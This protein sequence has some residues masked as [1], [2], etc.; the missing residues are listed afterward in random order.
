[1]PKKLGA[2]WGQSVRLA[3]AFVL[4]P[5]LSVSEIAP[6]LRITIVS[7]EFVSLRAGTI[8][9]MAFVL[10]GTKTQPPHRRLNDVL[11]ILSR[12]TAAT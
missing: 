7:P 4:A 6:E 5:T 11:P 1:M 2:P 3:P 8:R 10:A 9:T 12:A